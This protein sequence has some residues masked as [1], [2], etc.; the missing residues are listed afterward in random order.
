MA[1]L[2]SLTDRERFWSRVNKRGPL[3]NRGLGR[4]WTYP[5][6]IKTRYGK[7]WLPSTGREELAHRVS[8]LLAN[9]RWP[10]PC[11]LHKC[12]NTA[13]VRP[14]HLFE[15]T[16]QENMADCARKGRRRASQRRMVE[17]SSAKRKARKF[18]K[19]G[20]PYSEENT[21]Y[22]PRQRVCL[23]CRREATRKWRLLHG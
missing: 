2:I 16:H 20:H 18:C 13:C 1:D 4:C 12:D 6:Y 23:T 19:Q 22:T 14:S 17:L 10:K 15:G 8:F 9:G 21:R 5:L 11:A 7:F 3:L